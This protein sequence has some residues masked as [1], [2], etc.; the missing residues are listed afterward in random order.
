MSSELSR[1]LSGGAL[2][3]KFLASFLAF[4]T[5]DRLGRRAVFILSGFGMSACMVA[6]AVS[7]HFPT[8]NHGAQITAGCFLDLYNTFV[9]IGFLG[10]NFLYCAEVAPIRLRMAMSSISTANHWLWNFVVV[11]ITPVAINTIGWAY[12]IV[13]A[14]IGACIPI[15]VYLLFPETM[16]RNLEEIDMLF[17]ESP[18]VMATVKFAKTR[19]IAM[20]QEFAPERKVGRMADHIESS[21]DIGEVTE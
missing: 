3:W 20:P 18:S 21:K 7:T 1:V 5:I 10:A 8:S 13:F 14:A 2:T 15:S 17:R 11:M 12:Y 6:L 16:G 9:P 4:L 19:R